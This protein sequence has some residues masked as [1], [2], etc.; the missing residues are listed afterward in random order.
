MAVDFDSDILVTLTN[1]GIRGIPGEKGVAG[2]VG[3]AL[4]EVDQEPL[5]PTSGDVYFDDGTNSDSGAPSFRTWNGTIWIDSTFDTPQ[6]T[7]E[8]D[9]F[10]SS[11]L[12]VG[13]AIP[14]NL[15]SSPNWRIKRVD[16]SSGV[17]VLYADG[18][19]NF[20]NVWDDHLTLSYS[21]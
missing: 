21:L 10:T 4:S 12:Y 20:D 8:V 5:S 13:E 17:E 9:E 11:L 6:Y 2:P 14:G 18:D 3:P 16:T 15:T 19:S 7:I 1:V